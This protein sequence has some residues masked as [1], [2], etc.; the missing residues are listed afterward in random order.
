MHRLGLGLR[1]PLRLT[2]HH[3][4]HQAA[5]IANAMQV[6]VAHHKRKLLLDCTQD[7]NARKESVSG[8]KRALSFASCNRS[9]FHA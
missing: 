7:L 6:G 1:R 9:P 8:V 5:N 2:L 4:A 3:V